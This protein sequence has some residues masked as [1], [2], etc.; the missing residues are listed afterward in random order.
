MHLTLT[1]MLLSQLD[2]NDIF[3]PP[4]RSGQGLNLDVQETARG[5]FQFLITEAEDTPELVEDRADI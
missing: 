5:I 3:Q 2:E 1:D 4:D